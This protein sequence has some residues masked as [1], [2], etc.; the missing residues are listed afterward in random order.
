VIDLRGAPLESFEGSLT[1]HPWQ[2]VTLR[3]S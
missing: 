1:V 2:I 3:L